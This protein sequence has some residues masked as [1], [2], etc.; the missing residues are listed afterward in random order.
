MVGAQQHL[1]GQ[2]DEDQVVADGAGQRDLR[3]APALTQPGGQPKADNTTINLERERQDRIRNA[4]AAINA[5]FNDPGREAMY[6]SHRQNVYD[7]N[8]ERLNEERERGDRELKFALARTG[9]SGGTG[10][11]D[12]RDQFQKNYD[13]ALFDIAKFSDSA[14]ARFRNADESARLKLLGQAQSGM[15]ATTAATNAANQLALNAEQA[16]AY[17]DMA[18]LGDLFSNI[19]LLRQNTP[20]PRQQPRTDRRF[21]DDEYR[22]MFNAGSYGGSTQRIG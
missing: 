12:A 2:A 19:A 22:T 9:Q 11:I 4:T 1:V 8:L 6:G 15:S 17:N 7:Y 16:E 3:R 14:A 13:D 21:G 10:E 18:S 5:R 20:Q